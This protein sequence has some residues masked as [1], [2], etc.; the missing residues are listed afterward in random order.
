MAIDFLKLA[1]YDIG[2]GLA[3]ERPTQGEPLGG[4]L[5][6]YVATDTGDF[7]CWDGLV[8]KVLG[9]A[10]LGPVGPAGGDLAGTFPNPTIKPSVTLTTPNIGVATATSIN[11][12]VITPS[13]GT[14]T[15]AAAKTLTVSN[16]MTLQGTDGVTINFGAGGTFA[17]TSANLSVF[18]ATTSAQLLGVI[19]DETGT[20]A[21]VFA[22]TPT[23]V[24]PVIGAAT[25]TSLVLTGDV[26]A[27]THTNSSGTFLMISTAAFANGAASATGTLTNAPAAGNPT[28][29][30]PVN[31]NGTTRFIPA[32]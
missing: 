5:Y 29:W 27:A 17:Y 25:G 18:A 11:G 15:L 16:T 10:G 6:F 3:N 4:R 26:K 28:K 20:G 30:I 22:N 24:T 13:T 1:S 7:S 2:F 19:S 21:L 14:F 8:W 31:D 32:W 9:A 23:L 12:L